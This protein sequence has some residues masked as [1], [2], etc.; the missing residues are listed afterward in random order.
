VNPKFHNEAISQE[1]ANGFHT[2]P[3]ESNSAQTRLASQGLYLLGYFVFIGLSEKTNLLGF[4]TFQ[5][6]TAEC[7]N[8]K[9]KTK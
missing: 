8:T 1:H 2:E 9:S 3:D 5:V 4:V 7:M 6:L